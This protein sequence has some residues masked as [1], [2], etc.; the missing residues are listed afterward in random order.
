VDEEVR[1]EL[2]ATGGIASE[3][4]LRPRFFLPLAPAGHDVRDAACRARTIENDESHHFAPAWTEIQQSFSSDSSIS[5]KI[6]YSLIMPG[7]AGSGLYG[8]PTSVRAVSCGHA[9]AAFSR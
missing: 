6:H 8:A 1:E 5:C 9:P 3:S 2:I 7:R 4:G